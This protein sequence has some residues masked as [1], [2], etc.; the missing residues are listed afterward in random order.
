[1]LEINST[2]PELEDITLCFERTMAQIR[3]NLTD[4]ELLFKRII[5]NQVFISDEECAQ[6]LRCKKSEIPAVLP[7][8]RP[9]R[10]YYV[11]KLSEVIEFV[12]SKR[13]PKKQ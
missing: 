4:M 10:T 3:D 2:Y 11:Y 5:N 13:I 6:I 12:N 8:Y 7:K 1:M 9:S